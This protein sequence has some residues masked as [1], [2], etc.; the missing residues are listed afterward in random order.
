MAGVLIAKDDPDD[1]Q[2]DFSYM[3]LDECE[4]CLQASSD[5]VDRLRV[6]SVLLNNNFIQTVSSSLNQ[7]ENLVML[8]VSSNR[9]SI[10]ADESF[11]LKKLRVLIA[12]D[13]N[14]NDMSMPKS[15]SSQFANLEVIN[16][17]GNQFKNFPYQ[18]LDMAS[19]IEIHLGS[20]LI[21]TLPR[22]YENLQNLEVLY[23]GT[24]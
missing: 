8:N 5:V 15:F 7:F 24:L 20:N 19:L 21:E 6:K 13:N 1:T 4:T 18:L 2:L 9:L 3:D 16:L 12:S 11:V 22:N 17:S 23:L 10:V 14:F